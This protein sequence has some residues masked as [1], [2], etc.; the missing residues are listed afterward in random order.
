[1]FWTSRRLRNLALIAL[2]AIVVLTALQVWSAI[3]T[4]RVVRAAMEMPVTRGADLERERARQELIAKRIDN[5]SR[6]LLWT[7]VGAAVAAT[8]GLVLSIAGAA[9]TALA[10]LESREKERRD[11]HDAQVKERDD[12]LAGALSETLARLASNEARQRAVGAA[13]LIYFF[14]PERE[15]FHLQALAPLI[16]AART[17]NDD[18]VRQGLRL[19]MEH[20]MRA[21]RNAELRKLSWERLNLPDLDLSGCDLSGLDFRHVIL[22]RANLR[23]ANLSGADLS[24]A[25]LDGADLAEANLA[26]AN[27]SDAELAGATLAGAALPDTRIT[28]LRML[29]LDL[30]GARIGAAV[31]GWRGLPWEAARDWR[32]AEFDRAIR[33]ELDRTYGDPAPPLRVLM[34]VWEMPPTFVAGGTW[35]ACYHLVRK[36]R[37]RGADVTVVTPWSREQVADLPFGVDVPVVGLGIEP[38]A[39]EASPYGMPAW[40][41]YGTIW[42]TPGWSPYGAPAWSPYGGPAWSPY[43]TAWG[44]W[45]P[46]SPYG[47]NPYGGFGGFGGGWS[48]YGGMRGGAPSWSPYGR[49]AGIYGSYGSDP[50]SAGST[51]YRLMGEFSRRLRRYLADKSFD[52]IHAHD[53][54]TFDAAGSAAEARGTPWIAHFHST[55]SERQPDNENPLAEE[56]EREAVARADRLV[57]PS[58][59]TADL[60]AGRY[61][62]AADRLHVAPNLLSD[63]EP[64]TFNMGRFETRRVLF[65]GRLSHQKG[66]SL[67]IDIV[68]AGRPLV[69]FRAEVIGSGEEEALVA[70]HPWI[71]HEGAVAWDSRGEAFRGASL[72][73]V[74]S[75]FEP[76]GMVILEAMQHRVP[77]LYPAQSGAAE[78]LESGVRI[79]P[80]AA[81]PAAERLAGLLRD[82]TLW[83]ATVRAQVEEIEAYP[84]RRYEDRVIAAWTAAAES[85]R[86]SAA[87]GT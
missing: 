8:L 14:T 62:A 68:E 84:G 48:P 17:E 71:R 43:A 75:R 67:F 15:E 53:W 47:W 37:E 57:A 30:A 10:W 77:V 31:T 39:R 13:G 61:G 33:D 85:G 82:I 28:K 86:R 7:N 38:V 58:R 79:D 21:T 25:Q 29:N 55:E 73:V 4:Q 44:G 66:V 22:H 36:L 5:E 70:D 83:E 34:L 41:P 74:P 80:A 87:A 9:G 42:P 3:A 27:L 76:F 19:A 63:P 1:M 32:R 20:G 51:L 46:P 26:A 72:V 49:L 65:I 16:V 45:S 35:T 59:V 56:I 60:L 24:S 52:I 54:V 81:Q 23:G 69:D 40:S 78:V 6:A 11:R 64:A 18:N 2:T 12:R 50:A